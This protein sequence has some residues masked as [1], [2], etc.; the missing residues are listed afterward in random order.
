MADRSKPSRDA[1]FPPG[2]F[3]EALS[4]FASKVYENTAQRRPLEAVWVTQEMG[5]RLGI[6]PGCSMEIHTEA[7]YVTVRASLGTEALPPWT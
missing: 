3:V 1:I 2:W 4:K 7:G 5:L 6:A